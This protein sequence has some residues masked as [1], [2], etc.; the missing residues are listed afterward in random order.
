MAGAPAG[1]SPDYRRGSQTDISDWPAV[2][3]GEVGD[4]PHS[5][6]LLLLAA[7]RPIELARPNRRPAGRRRSV[8]IT[9]T[10]PNNFGIEPCRQLRHRPEWPRPAHGRRCGKS[11]RLQAIHD[12]PALDGHLIA[13]FLDERIRFDQVAPASAGRVPRRRPPSSGGE[14][15]R[16]C[17]ATRRR[18]ARL[19]VDANRRRLRP[20]GNAQLQRELVRRT[21]VDR[22]PHVAVPRIIRR[23][24]ELAAA[25]R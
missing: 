13:S 22:D 9:V 6:L 11:V 14:S 24:R 23:L 15:R 25:C 21:F 17:S 7:E 5:D 18:A 16:S 20:A 8:S 19:A 1:E 4:E 3:P 12:R 2:R 10:P